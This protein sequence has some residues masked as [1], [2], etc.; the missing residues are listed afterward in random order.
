LLEP[1]IFAS[2]AALIG[3]STSAW[4]LDMSFVYRFFF[5]GTALLM[6]ISSGGSDPLRPVTS[7]Q[8]MRLPYHLHLVNLLPRGF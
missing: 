2:Q 5:G 4:Y 6:F 8:S 3:Q 1:P 7:P